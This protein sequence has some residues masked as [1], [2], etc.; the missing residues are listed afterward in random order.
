MK[1][2]LTR[3]ELQQLF[4]EALKGNI[5]LDDIT[6]STKAQLLNFAK[7]EQGAA[8]D[9]IDKLLCANPSTTFEYWANRSSNYIRATKVIDWITNYSEAAPPQQTTNKNETIRYTAKHY[10]LAYL[11]E[12][13]AKGESYPIGQ[14]KELE[15]IGNIRMG[16]GRG[17]TFYKA[18]N[19]VVNKDINAENNLIEIG[20]ENWRAI[21]KDISSEPETIETYLQSKQL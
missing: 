1:I 4:D 9:R 8:I 17:N 18:F 15:K 16:A 6:K 12:C 11:I 19:I 7:E 3:A 13:N 14:K 10:V 21:V 5:Y 20:G 2:V